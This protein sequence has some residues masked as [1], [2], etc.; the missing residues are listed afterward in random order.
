MSR[1][2]LVCSCCIEGAEEAPLAGSSVNVPFQVIGQSR[3][4]ARSSMSR[5]IRKKRIS[6][7][8]FLSTGLSLNLTSFYD[9]VIASIIRRDLNS[10]QLSG[11]RVEIGVIASIVHTNFENEH[12]FDG[13]LKSVVDVPLR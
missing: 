8:D 7:I 9:E 3:A 1:D 5:E 11:D 6:K 2:F 4:N 12:S 10:S 13:C